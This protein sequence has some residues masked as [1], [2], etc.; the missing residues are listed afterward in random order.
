MVGPGYGDRYIT[1]SGEQEVELPDERTAR[2]MSLHVHFPQ[3]TARSSSSDVGIMQSRSIPIHP[4]GSFDCGDERIDQIV[5]LCLIHAEVTMSDTYVD[6]PGRED[7]QWIEDDRPRADPGGPLV[8]RQPAAALHDPHLRPE[9]G[10]GRQ[11]HPFAPSNYPAYPAPYDWSVQWVAALYDDY[12]WT[13]QTDL[14]ERHWDTLTRYWDNVLSHTG[15]D[16]V[17][18]TSR[19]Y[20]DIR[21][22]LQPENDK[23][24]SGIVTPWIIERLGWSAEMAEATGKKEQAA[25]WR[26]HATR[27]RPRSGNSM[28]FRPRARSRHMSATVSTPRIPTSNAAT[29]R[30]GRP[31]RSSPGFSLPRRRAPT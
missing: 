20:A 15:E 21:I 26:A 24:S 16:G 10:Q 5:K 13:G 30:P 6:T 19:V 18:R 9:P 23:Q 17:W 22:G 12:L 11:F 28:S 2:W 14:I 7:G 1:A 31:W 29:A 27:W 8:R 25:R 3:P 4:A